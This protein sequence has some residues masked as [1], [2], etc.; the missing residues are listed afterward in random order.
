MNGT[1]AVHTGWCW[2]GHEVDSTMSHC[3]QC[4]AALSFPETSDCRACRTGKGRHTCGLAG[5]QDML[6][7]GGGR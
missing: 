6:R 3:P 7:I 4:G 1:P 2:R 5:L